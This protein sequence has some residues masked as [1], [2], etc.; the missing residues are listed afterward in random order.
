MGYNFTSLGNIH[1]L[2]GLFALSLVL[3]LWKKRYAHGAIYILFFELAAAIWAISDGFENASISLPQKLFWAKAGYIGII[4]CA[5][6]FLMFTLAYTR[7]F[8]FVNI[9]TFLLLMII[10]V[11]TL[12]LAFTSSW[13]KLIWEK[14]IILPG[15]HQGVYYYGFWFWIH[16]FYEYSVITIGIVILLIYAF[17]V[18]TLYKIQ[19]WL[20]ILGL[21]LPFLSNVL[22]IFKLT[23]LKGIDLTPIS[24]ILTGTII[25]INF[26]WLRMLDIIPIARSLAIDNIRDGILV[27]DSSNK[28]VDINSAFYIISGSSAK[29][30]LGNQIERVLSG[31]NVKVDDISVENEYTTETQIYVDEVQQNYEVKYHPVLN[32]NH[33]IIGKIIILHDITSR[34]KILEE[35]AESNNKLR[36]EIFEKEKLILDLDAFANT[37]AHSLKNPINSVIGL[38]TL[39]KERLT[40]G[41]NNEVYEMLEIVQNQ[42]YRMCKIIDGLLLLASIRKED[43]KPEPIDMAKILYEA[44]D[45]LKTQIEETKAII[46][47]PDKWPVVMGHHQWIEEVWVNLLSNALKYGGSS[48]IVRLG[49]E[50]TDPTKYQFWIQDNGNGLPQESYEKI[51]ED[52]ERLGRNDIEGYGL[53]LSTV[54]RIIEKLGS[55]VSVTSSNE[56][57]EGC[58]FSFTLDEGYN[59]DFQS[60]KN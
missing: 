5:V 29:Q 51:F 49:F 25:A 9:K 20:L 34:K 57:G 7:R 37:V 48:P 10:P 22:Y 32:K 53:G 55:K 23:S 56:P 16:A 30:L 13:H 1:L 17:R 31:I 21:I 40:E 4:N 24:F 50:K 19:I 8:Q 3:F 27:A 33:K 36:K 42:G 15:T 39:I 41:K 60:E 2:S 59:E 12:I 43:I 45:R 54:K 46:I 38:S 28:I 47:K 14:V 58:I 18:Y 6:L 35:I 11:I 26:Y 44:F 52:F